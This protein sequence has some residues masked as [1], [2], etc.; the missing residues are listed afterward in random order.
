MRQSTAAEG[1]VEQNQLGILHDQSGE[2][3]PLELAG[4]KGLDRAPLIT[5]EADRAK[6]PLRSLAQLPG[7]RACPSDPTPLAEQ[8]G[9]DY[10]NRKTPFDLGV[11]GQIGDPTAARDR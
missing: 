6:G 8:Y 7:C 11:L 2:K 5:F 10:G 1:L 9:L 3:D 4:G